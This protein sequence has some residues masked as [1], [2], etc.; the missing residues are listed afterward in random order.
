MV[1]NK[2]EINGGFI[3]NLNRGKKVIVGMSGGV[4]SSVAAY[5]LKEQGYEVE[6]VYMRNWDSAANSDILGNPTVNDEICPQE[7]DYMDALAVADQLGI[8]LHRVDFV[9]EYWNRVFMYFLNEYKA[10]RTPNPDIMCNKEVKFKAF[11]DYAMDLGCDYIAMGHY[12]RLDHTNEVNMLRG[13]DNNKDQTYFLSQLSQD[14]LSK[15]LFP[16]GELQKSEVRAIAEK[17]ELATAKKKDSTGVCFIGERNFT[18]FLQNYLPAQN[19]KMMS[20]EGEILGEHVGLMYYTIGQRKGLGIG[21]KG[22]AWFVIGKNLEENILYVGQ[23][24]DHEYVYADEAIVT[25]VNWISQEK[26]EGICRC[27]AKFRYRQPD[28]EVEI[29]WLDET[30]LR[31]KTLEPVRAITPG[32]AAV[33]YLDDICLGGGLIDSAYRNGVKRM[34]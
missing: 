25:D 18:Q 11:L 1:V 14:Q 7:V 19:G 32:Q 34:Y 20:L 31:V 9:E 28:I 17:L 4:D 6:G 21:G 13:H 23:G 5:I 10:G 26:F 2:I 15:T 22:D 24:F 12:A 3:M 8:K 27:T 29:E 30:T 16:I 33:F